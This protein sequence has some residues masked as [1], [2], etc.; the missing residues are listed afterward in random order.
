MAASENLQAQGWVE[1][2]EPGFVWVRTQRETACGGCQG[3]A[4]CGTGSLAK[5]FAMGSQ[6][7]LKLPNDLN[8][9]PGDLV[10]LELAGGALVQQAFIAY[11]VPLV[12]LFAGALL[13]AFLWQDT[14][15]WQVVLGSGA[16]L[17]MAWWLVKRFHR[18]IQP[19]ITRIIS[20]SNDE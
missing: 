1:S 3:E 13:V 6:P 12:G 8:A 19:K 18:P 2:A 20:K 9:R 17:V 11:G 16:G 5:M 7:L 15:D 4:T 10:A 14:A